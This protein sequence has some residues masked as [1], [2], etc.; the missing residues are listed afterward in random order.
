MIMEPVGSVIR[1]SYRPGKSETNSLQA[2]SQR[3][4]NVAGLDNELARA[5]QAVKAWQNKANSLQRRNEQLETE[6]MVIK[7][8][9]PQLFMIN[10]DGEA[11]DDDEDEDDVEGEDEEDKGEDKGDEGEEKEGDGEDEEDEEEEEEEPLSRAELAEELER[12]KERLSEM[13]ELYEELLRQRNN[14]MRL[15]RYGSV[16]NQSVKTKVVELQAEM[17]QL[18]AK[19]REEISKK[20]NELKI[21]EE[22]AD[23]DKSKLSI[24]RKELEDVKTEKTNLALDKKK[25]E[26]NLQKVYSAKQKRREQTEDSIKEME[27]STLKLKNSRLQMELQKV[28][29]SPPLSLYS[30]QENLFDSNPN[31]SQE[32]NKLE[33]DSITDGSTADGMDEIFPPSLVGFRERE[34]ET[35]VESLKE[36][37]VM[38]QTR[39][40]TESEQKKVMV[41]QWEKQLTDSEEKANSLEIE[42][43]K[44]NQEVEMLTNELEMAET[45][46]EELSS[47]LEETE[48]ELA[49]KLKQREDELDEINEALEDAQGQLKNVPSDTL[50]LQKKVTKLQLELGEAR[51]TLTETKTQLD[52]E[53]VTVSWKNEEIAQL[54][55]KLQ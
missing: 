40:S 36:E 31:K 53:I 8:E 24:L 39:L 45:S 11:E 5:K 16:D 43:E 33:L 15:K 37:I 41:E 4:V 51:R 50:S 12:T 54:R 2:D 3:D 44:A 27:V 17:E 7:N 23:R 18:K 48:A 49:E 22:R 30:S 47:R 9:N 34:L 26:R 25:L 13:T 46:A 20:D 10:G 32:L 42:L 35:E 1:V 6:I 28:Q 52:K 55:G 29:R 21:V 38:L 14:E 19:H